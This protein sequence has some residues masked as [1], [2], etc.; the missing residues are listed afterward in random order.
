MAM[1][2]DSSG[3]WIR[4]V[5]LEELEVHADARER[6]ADLVGDEAAILRRRRGARLRGGGAA[7]REGGR[8]CG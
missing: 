2:S 5:L 1:V 3:G 7:F 4:E 6:V 8:A